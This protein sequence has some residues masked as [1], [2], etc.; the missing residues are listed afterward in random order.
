MWILYFLQLTGGV[1]R[2]ILTRFVEGDPF[3]ISTYSKFKYPDEILWDWTPSFLANVDLHTPLDWG[4]TLFG[5]KVLGGW[6]IN[7]I[8]SWAQGS[9]FTWNPTN[10]PF[11]RNN[12]QWADSFSND[13]FVSKAVTIGKLPAVFYCDIHNLFSRKLLNVGVLNGLAE[14]PGSEKYNYFAS[15][16]PGDRVGHY[17]ASHIV[18]PKEKP[19]ENY[20]YRVGGPVKVFAGLRLNFDFGR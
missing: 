6:R 8:L 7:A 14:S 17:K 18:R 2:S 13:F 20:I 5:A 3:N 15:L 10:S 11:I 12:L 16:R 19:G 4:P 9:K 1:S